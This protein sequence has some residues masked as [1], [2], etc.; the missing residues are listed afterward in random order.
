MNQPQ[1]H[2]ELVAP[3]CVVVQDHLRNGGT[4]RQSVLLANHLA[5][6]GWRVDLLTF[7]PGGAL[8]RSGLTAGELVQPTVL[9]PFDSGLPLWAPGLKRWL[10]AAQPDIVVCMGRTANCYAGAMQRW[11]PGSAVIGS[12]RTGKRILALQRWSW[13]H[14]RGLVVNCTWW[15]DTLLRD[16]LSVPIEV[17]RNPL[18]HRAPTPHLRPTHRAPAAADPLRLL[19]VASFRRG[20]NQRQLL[21]EIAALRSEE[22]DL[23]W[24]LDLVGDGPHIGACRRLAQRLG[25][26]DL[27]HFHGFVADPQPFYAAADIAVSLSTEDALPN[28]MIEAQAAGLPV[29]AR[30]YRGVRE[31][32]IDG[33]SGILVG[34]GAGFRAA[35]VRLGSDPAL[36]DTMACAGRQFAQ[37]A[38]DPMQQLSAWRAA[39]CRLA[40]MR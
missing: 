13:R 25:I 29:V 3:R 20:K 14:I 9:Q 5:T 2:G 40:G 38:F 10:Q 15:R 7:R 30:D 17:V 23:L 1:E 34:P 35:L 16:G 39:L 32:F 28:F 8:A 37:Q 12:L 18:L 11:L 22:P 24:R 36:R 19:Q 21:R 27:V 26:A 6:T 33:T 4:E 31:T